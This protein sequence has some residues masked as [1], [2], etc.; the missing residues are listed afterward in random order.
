MGRLTTRGY[1]NRVGL[2]GKEK[3]LSSMK[4]QYN[5]N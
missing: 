3:V 5:M 1:K 2:L 4:S